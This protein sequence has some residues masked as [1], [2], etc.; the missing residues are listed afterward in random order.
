MSSI[1]EGNNSFICK[2]GHETTFCDINMDLLKQISSTR[3]N[4]TSVVA[5]ENAYLTVE[6]LN[7]QLDK[8]IDNN[9]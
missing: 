1:D 6:S 5:T 4:N 3:V 2:S 7:L 8:F 9:N